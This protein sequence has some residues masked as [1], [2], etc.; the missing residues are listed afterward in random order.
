MNARLQ[1]TEL[2][3]LSVRV[4]QGTAFEAAFAGVSH[5]LA[6]AQGQIRHRLVPSVDQP[7]VYLLE[8]EWADLAAHVET[9]EPG[10]GH[11]VFMAA[12]APFLT[13]EPYVIHVPS[14]REPDGSPQSAG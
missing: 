9:F 1:V 2:A 4:G 11:A 12:L 8:V 3:L 14:L 13:A 6:S 10:A 5:L 7:Q